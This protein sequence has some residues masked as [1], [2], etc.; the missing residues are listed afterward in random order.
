MMHKIKS[1]KTKDNL[2]IIAT[3]MDGTVKEYDISALFSALPQLKELKENKAL[4]HNVKM[5]VGGYGIFWNDELDLEAE[6]IWEDGIEV[7]KML[8]EEA[9]ANLMENIHVMGTKANC[10]W[11]MESKAQLEAGNISTYELIEDYR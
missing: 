11:V 7:E 10:D 9:Y 2:I 1:V 4:F 6:T 8:F 3:F 5:D